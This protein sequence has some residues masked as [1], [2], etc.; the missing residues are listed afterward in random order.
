LAI[1]TRFGYDYQHVLFPHAIDGSDICPI[2]QHAMH[3]LHSSIGCHTVN[4]HK[5]HA[6][7]SMILAWLCS[8]CNTAS[9]VCYA[10][11]RAVDALP[12]L[13]QSAV[14]FDVVLSSE[15]THG[16]L[17][18]FDVVIVNPFAPSN[19]Q[20]ALEGRLLQEAEQRKLAHYRRHLGDDRVVL[21][22]PDHPFAVPK[23]VGDKPSFI[24]HPFAVSA[25][26]IIGSC[27]VNSLKFLLKL[28][29]STAFSH[30]CSTIQNKLVKSNSSVRDDY[31]RRLSK[32]GITPAILFSGGMSSP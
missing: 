18:A 11:E 31:Y 4:R 13:R 14:R 7:H 21:F 15:L 28:G 1:A 2:C 3:A 29:C 10:C 30:M 23:P 24:L 26:G 8:L 32:Q 9:T 6:R 20:S 12:G 27:G 17:H 25:S 16:G 19:G 5:N 22:D